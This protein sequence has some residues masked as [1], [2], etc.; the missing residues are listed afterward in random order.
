MANTFNPSISDQRICRILHI[1]N[2][3]D[4]ISV[5]PYGKET[6]SW[7][8]EFF[9]TEADIAMELAEKLNAIT[10]NDA[11]STKLRED[12]KTAAKERKVH[13]DKVKDTYG[14]SYVGVHSIMHPYAIIKLAGAYD[15][16][17]NKMIDSAGQRKWYETGEIEARSSYTQSYAKNPTTSAIIK[18]CNADYMGR[19]PYSFQDFVFCKYWNKIQNN[20]MITL[21]RYPGPVNDAVEPAAYNN[22]EKATLNENIIF[23]PLATAVTYFGGDTGN[24]LSEILAFS[25]GYNWG[26]TKGDIWNIS[27]NPLEGS[28]V[29]GTGI[30]KWIPSGVGFMAKALGVFGDLMGENEINVEAAR[31]LP[32]DPYSSGPYENRIIGPVNVINT[33]KKRERGLVFRQDG[34]SITFKYVARPIANINTK[35]V[36]LDIL[37]NMMVMTSSDG[38]FFGGMH[39]FRQDKPAIYP[40]RNKDVLNKLYSGKLFGTDGA[41]ASTLKYAW[42]TGSKSIIG[43]VS[44][45]V[46]DIK[47]SA[48]D[49]INGIKN[50]V[51]GVKSG[52]TDTTVSDAKQS[53]G[54]VS[55]AT[56]SVISTVENVVAA[57]MLKGMQIPWL[58]GAKAILTGE[59]IGDW[60]LTIG[61]PMNPIAVIGNLIMK[62]ATIKFSDELGPDDF[63]T[64]MEITVRLEHGM[65]RDRAGAESMFNRGYGRIYALSDNMKSS[66]DYETK[67]DAYTGSTSGNVSTDANGNITKVNGE[68]TNDLAKGTALA[69]SGKTDAAYGKANTPLTNSGSDYNTVIDRATRVKMLQEN[70]GKPYSLNNGYWIAPWTIRYTL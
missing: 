14:T 7:A 9:N 25:V 26:E 62:E 2:T 21:R 32:P 43:F 50:T 31:G 68:A 65:G 69:V 57:R 52:D 63:P 33:V 18:Y 6:S 36:M 37:A 27:V 56:S 16:S 66:A 40:F 11:E 24:K 38:T 15:A 1:Q 41:L 44:D 46:S 54:A 45:L 58:Q 13:I 49:L 10:G 61:N 60:H 28:N 12:L 47:N 19:F 64:E 70:T 5:E 8:G 29:M 23:N 51:N 42:D 67:L 20:R 3:G 48:S 34:L 30:G 55:N 35:A 39:R 4:T 17:V 53:A 59:P 22:D